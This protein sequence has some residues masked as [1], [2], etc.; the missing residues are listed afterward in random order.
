[1]V[2]RRLCRHSILIGQA[3]AARLQRWQLEMSLTLLLHRPHES[4]IQLALQSNFRGVLIPD[5]A[6]LC[7]MSGPKAILA[8]TL[9]HS[10]QHQTLHLPLSPLDGR[11][12][13]PSED[14]L[15]QLESQF[16]PRLLRYRLDSLDRVRDSRIDIPGLRPATR[17]LA[18]MLAAC[19]QGHDELV[20]Q[21]A[22]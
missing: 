16:Q 10:L 15:Q 19:I 22:P 14:V 2:L 21:V 12:P 20:Q 13:C 9:P 6:G 11:A 5:A 1:H 17:T 8:D 3:S 7:D 18:N 4:A